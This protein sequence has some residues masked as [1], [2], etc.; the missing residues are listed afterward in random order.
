MKIAILTLPLHTNYGGI[1]Q[2]YAL[3][4]YLKQQGHSP[5]VILLQL[6]SRPTYRILLSLLKS[7]ILTVLGKGNERRVLKELEGRCHQR[8]VSKNIDKFIRK[9]IHFSPSVQSIETLQ[10]LAKHRYDAFIVG[11]DQVWRR[12][13][14]TSLPVEYFFLD[15]VPENIIKIA[16][17]AS[18]GTDK[19]EYD[20]SEIDKCGQA[21]SKL[22]FISVREMSG[23]SLIRKLMWQN[24]NTKCEHILD[25]TFLFSKDF[26]IRK[27][28]LKKTNTNNLELFSYILEELVDKDLLFNHLPSEYK[29]TNIE[30]S[31]TYFK[32][33]QSE[34]LLS[35]QAWL[36][37]IYGSSAIITD[38][39]HCC[40]FAIIFQLPFLAVLNS[41]R[42]NSRLES[43]LKTFKIENRI[44]YHPEEL[45]NKH[46]LLSGY[47]QGESKSINEIL[48]YHRNKS[49]AF[50]REA[51]GTVTMGH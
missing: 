20:L 10:K 50:L 35:P 31:D 34:V 47:S 24:T 51:L 15:F 27:F 32:D 13:Y 42:G 18:F 28:N 1:L 25:P 5:E 22:N 44:V 11:S 41:V 30:S 45:E 43:L 38:S 2:A 46:S 4:E 8:Y 17:S 29:I 48:S 33:S 3:Q 21:Y 26:Y 36:E 40:V 39:F 49:T 23:I 14:M 37:T 12:K 7:F 19:V 9:H 16:F 6:Y